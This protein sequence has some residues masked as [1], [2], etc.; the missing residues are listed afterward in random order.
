MWTARVPAT[1]IRPLGK[2]T[3]VNIKPLLFQAVHFQ[4]KNIQN[5]PLQ[6]KPSFTSTNIIITKNRDS[7]WPIWIGLHMK[8]NKTAKAAWIPMHFQIVSLNEY[9]SWYIIYK[10][11]KIKVT[12]YYLICLSSLA[13]RA[14][15]TANVCL[16][17]KKKKNFHFILYLLGYTQ[18]TGNQKHQ[19]NITN[20]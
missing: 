6:G 4:S 16:A 14:E 18:I 8:A 10:K 15:K 17:L 19:A 5:K 11:L 9:L 2:T 13:I 20:I 1:C 3:Q 7:I 12:I